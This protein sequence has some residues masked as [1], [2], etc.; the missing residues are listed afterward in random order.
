M[1]GLFND[2]DTLDKAREALMPDFQAAFE[3]EGFAL[4]GSGDVG[5]AHTMSKGKEVRSPDDLKNLKVYAWSD[6]PI[7]PVTSSV[8]GYTPVPSSVPELLPKLSSGAINVITVPA[9]PAVALQW[10]AHLDHVNEDVAGVG[11]GGLVMSKKS[12][13]S[14]NGD[15]LDVV[16]KSGK[17]AG[18][19]LTK[20]I[21][22]EDAKAYDDIK[23][24]MTPV[25]L[26]DA[27]KTV[28]ANT[29]KKVRQQLGQGTFSSEL[30]R[31][32]EGLAGK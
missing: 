29:F 16:K 8:I 13:D 18:D 21:R 23:G 12:L 4:L 30:V 19:L 22:L 20:K 15:E 7:A 32:L 24:T 17:K 31:K 11:V 2:W 5:L 28:W 26:S 14:L 25:K 6:D 27:E 9:L 10:R 3:K 1:P